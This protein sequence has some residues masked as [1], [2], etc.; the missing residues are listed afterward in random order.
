MLKQIDETFYTRLNQYCPESAKNVLGKL[1]EI[2][3]YCN[4]STVVTTASRVVRRIRIDAQ[5]IVDELKKMIGTTTEMQEKSRLSD[6]SNRNRRRSEYV[7]TSPEVV[8]TNEWRR[9]QTI[10]EFVQDA[11]NVDNEHLLVPVLLDLLKMCLTF[12]EQNPLEYTNQLVL[13]TLYHLAKK[14]VKDLMTGAPL[15]IGLIGKIKQKITI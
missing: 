6:K 7:P 3:T 15:H 8:N 14:N 12:E 5:M 13:S 1:V 11:N 10:L 2:V 4:V 9:G